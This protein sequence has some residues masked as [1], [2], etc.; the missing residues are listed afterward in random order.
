[1]PVSEHAIV[2]LFSKPP[3]SMQWTTGDAGR[4][5]M[6]KT[7]AVL[8]IVNGRVSLAGIFPHDKPVIAQKNGLLMLLLLHEL[9]PDWTAAGAWLASAMRS[10]QRDV[11]QT[12]E[13]V[14][15][16]RQP[17]FSYATLIVYAL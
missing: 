11:A 16:I 3:I 6:G 5:G 4:F 13:R 9:R 1:M 17:E 15:L 12:D 7:G 8:E 2:E 10:S 14:R